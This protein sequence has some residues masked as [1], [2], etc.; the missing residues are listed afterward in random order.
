MVIKISKVRRNELNC[1]II[2]ITI[3]ASAA[4]MPAASL[5]LVSSLF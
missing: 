2:A 4:G 1:R 3:T 5:P